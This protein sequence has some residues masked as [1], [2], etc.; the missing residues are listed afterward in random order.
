[1]ETRSAD[2]D[3]VDAL[4]RLATDASNLKATLSIREQLEL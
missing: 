1:M 2:K 3:F 4:V